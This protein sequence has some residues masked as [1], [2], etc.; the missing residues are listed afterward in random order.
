MSGWI[1]WL[2]VIG[3]A[4]VTLAIRASFIVLPPQTRLPGWLLEC[5]KYVGAA[6]LPALIAPEVMVRDALPGDMFNWVR[7][8]AALAAMLFALRTR[9]VF[10]TLVV[11]MAVL[12][13]L[14]WLLGAK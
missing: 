2:T 7:I 8:V 13:L 11:G 3:A 6:V 9:S 12:W 1:A 4:A 10:G 5:L 14:Q